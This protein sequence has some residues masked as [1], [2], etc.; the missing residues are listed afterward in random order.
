MRIVPGEFRKESKAALLQAEF[1]VGWIF[2]SVLLFDLVKPW[3]SRKLTT[4]EGKACFLWMP[5]K[6]SPT[7]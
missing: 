2:A 7:N 6:I 3:V 4:K 5:I 1:R